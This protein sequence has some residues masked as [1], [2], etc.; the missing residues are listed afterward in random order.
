MIEITNNTFIEDLQGINEMLFFVYLQS[1]ATNL[2]IYYNQF[3]SKSV[4]AGDHSSNAKDY[5]TAN[6]WY[7]PAT[8]TSFLYIF[9]IVG[10]LS[11]V[12]LLRKKFNR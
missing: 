12:T 4:L 3:F 5:G 6:T 10:L 9:G 11:M 8:D 1:E 7:N 2:N